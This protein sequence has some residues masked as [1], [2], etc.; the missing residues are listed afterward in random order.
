MS[1][2]GT[3]LCVDWNVSNRNI[4]SGGEDCMYKVWDSF[5]RQLYSSRYSHSMS[6]C[7]F[8]MCNEYILVI[9]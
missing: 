6:A 1:C 5:G 4:V 9:Y 2:S 8:Y 7:L 3:V